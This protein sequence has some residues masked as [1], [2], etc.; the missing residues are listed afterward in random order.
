MKRFST[1]LY[2]F[3]IFIPSSL[4][5]PQINQVDEACPN[6]MITYWK[7]DEYGPVNTFLDSYN[8]IN[9]TTTDSTR[10]VQDVGVVDQARKFDGK[11]EIT[12]P[13]NSA[14]DWGTHTS[15]SI[16]LWIKTNQPGTGNKVFIGKY[17][18]NS[19]MAWW[20]GYGS[21]NKTIFSVSDSSGIG[22]EFTG[23]KVIADN[24][25]HY[26][27]AVKND[28]MRVLQIY[29]DGKEDGIISTFFTGDFKGTGPLYIGYFDNN[30]HF[31]GLL[32][33]IALYNR[34]LSNNE[35][36]QHYQDGLSGKSYCDPSTTDVENNNNNI[37]NSFSLSQNYPN[38]FNPTTKIKFTIPNIENG[39]THPLFVT[40]KV[41]DI[42][43]NEI[44]TLVNEEKQPGSYQVTL[45]GDALTSGVYFYRLN[46]GNFSQT[47]KFILIK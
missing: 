35:I 15:F 34:I 43:G 7:L 3:F 47:R 21:E 10:P 29:V 23:T 31:N 32:D 26:I 25:W 18:G 12:V 41:Y 46:A 27:V 36:S 33:E 13:E 1:S 16:E 38:P 24:K 19:K 11:S 39:Y 14:F 6:G 40:L 42:L 28:S 37:P 4:L 9:G 17:K 22:T 20:L 2:V 5:F 8:G 44:S 45:D 30:Y